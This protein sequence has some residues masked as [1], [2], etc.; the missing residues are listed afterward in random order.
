MTEPTLTPRQ[1]LLQ[2][3]S[4]RFCD[5]WNADFEHGVAFLNR[6]AALEFK[7]KYPQTY[8]AINWVHNLHFDAVFET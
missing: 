7:Q 2:E 8:E 4:E 1:E 3:I 5:A 6:N